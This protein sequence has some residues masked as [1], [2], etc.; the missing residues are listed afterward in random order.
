MT[1]TR[2]E[3]GMGKAF[4]DY[5]D[6]CVIAMPRRWTDDAPPVNGRDVAGHTVIDLVMLP[7]GTHGGE[8]R[9]LGALMS[10]ADVRDTAH[11]VFTLD[12]TDAVEFALDLLKLVAD[13]ATDHDL[14]RMTLEQL[15]A[16]REYRP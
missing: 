5:G 16:L 11:Q 4:A 9:T 6:E 2:P 10:S 7:R 1:E 12:V 8:L 14:E 15:G 3:G 13:H